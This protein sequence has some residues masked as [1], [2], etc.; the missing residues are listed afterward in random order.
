MFAT[1]AFAHPPSSVTAED[2]KAKNEIV[3]IVF[4]RISTDRHEKDRTHFIKEIDLEIN[5]EI[6]DSQTF[7]YQNHPSIVRARFSM[8][9]HENSDK[10]VIKAIC[11]TGSELDN[12][13]LISNLPAYK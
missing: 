3:V 7:N 12:D 10:L 8:P 1:P 2:D 9:K 11:S 13:I 4:H 6:V 5:G